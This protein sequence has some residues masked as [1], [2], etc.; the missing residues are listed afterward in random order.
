MYNDKDF[1]TLKATTLKNLSAVCYNAK[2]NLS[3]LGN[4]A[5]KMF[6]NVHVGI[7]FKTE[8]LKNKK[9]F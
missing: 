9:A 2:K 1:L 4:S 8:Y 3:V 5:K 6:L 7:N